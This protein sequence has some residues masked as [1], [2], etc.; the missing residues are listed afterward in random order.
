[1]VNYN[2]RYNNNFLLGF[3]LL[4]LTLFCYVIFK[5]LVFKDFINIYILETLCVLVFFILE[6]TVFKLYKFFLERKNLLVTLGII[7]GNVLLCVLVYGFILWVVYFMI[8]FMIIDSVGEQNSNLSVLFF[9]ELL[10]YQLP[11][12]SIVI[13]Y[14]FS[15][16]KTMHSLRNI[17]SQPWFFLKPH[18]RIL[19]LWVC[20]MFSFKFSNSIYIIFA[21]KLILDGFYYLFNYSGGQ[22]LMV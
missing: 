10:K 5:G 8:N 2:F 14:I 11:L 3:I 17:D 16:L 18:F 22:K 12:V 13:F 20:I 7:V 15:F 6:F 4:D 21:I 19:V 9:G 1:M